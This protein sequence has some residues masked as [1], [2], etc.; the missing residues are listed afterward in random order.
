MVQ[1]H[2]ILHLSL[3]NE[4][5][6]NSEQTLQDIEVSSTQNNLSNA[7][8]LQARFRPD[9][10]TNSQQDVEVVD[11]YLEG[12]VADS[13]QNSIIHIQDGIN[14]LE[15]PLLGGL[16][17]K[18]GDGVSEFLNTLTDGIRSIGQFTPRKLESYINEQLSSILGPREEGKQYATINTPT[19]DDIV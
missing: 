10:F 1:M 15:L 14:T 8:I 4:L 13:I 7:D 16:D 5:T 17:G 11:K 18:T 6:I 9:H 12:N 19:E 3:K 2:N